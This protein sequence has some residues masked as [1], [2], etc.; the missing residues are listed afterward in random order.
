M[1]LQ[2]EFT[3]AASLPLESPAVAEAVDALV[4]RAIEES[5]A[6]DRGERWVRLSIHRR[7]AALSLECGAPGTRPP[8]L[9]PLSALGAVSRLTCYP[10]SYDLSVRWSAQVEELPC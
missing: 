4:T 3:G 10:T 9:A 6:L 5:A 1:Y 2:Y 8:D 7:C